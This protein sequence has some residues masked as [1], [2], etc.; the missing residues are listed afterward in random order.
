MLAAATGAVPLALLLLAVPGSL[1]LGVVSFPL[2][3]LLLPG[4]HF[5]GMLSADLARTGGDPLLLSPSLQASYL[6]HFLLTLRVSARCS[7]SLQQSLTCL[8]LQL[9]DKPSRE[10]CTSCCISQIGAMTLLTI[11][12][13]RFDRHIVSRLQAAGSSQRLHRIPVDPWAA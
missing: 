6:V 12:H 11:T 8:K 10:S 5:M 4:V 13:P 2:Q 9:A 1:A 7:D 3:L